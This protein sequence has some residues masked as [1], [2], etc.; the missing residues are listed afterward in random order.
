LDTLKPIV[1]LALLTRCL[2]AALCF[3]DE[4]SFM[5][6]KPASM[7]LANLLLVL[8]PATTSA[9]RLFRCVPYGERAPLGSPTITCDGRVPGATLELT[10]W[11]DNE[12]PDD[13]YADTSTECA[14]RLARL[15]REGGSQY[16]D[17]DDALVINN[18]FDT[19]GVLSAFAC[20]E[21]EAALRHAVLLADGAAAGDFGEWTSDAGVRLD[22]AI[23]AIGSAHEAEGDAAAYDAALEALP[24][25][26]TSLEEE[27][28]DDDDA[29]APWR[30]GWEAASAG[31][32][33]LTSGDASLSRAGA[34]A[35]L[36]EPGVGERA[37]R[38]PPA[39]LHRG[40]TQLLGASSGI[41]RVLRVTDGGAKGFSYEYEKPG[42]GWVK[43][44]VTREPVVAPDGGALAESLTALGGVGAWRKGGAGGLIALCASDGWVDAPPDAVCEAL[45]ACDEE[46]QEYVVRPGSCPA[47]C[48]AVESWVE[49]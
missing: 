34:I 46:A 17:H 42:H 14:L 12:T 8:A 2:G 49:S 18:H 27:E 40:L 19:D 21:P 10:H 43:R 48:G 33:A 5:I 22:A 28:A 11:T 30:D 47:Q 31:W 24:A 29:D 9:L 36:R 32:H 3:G 4:E 45:L 23:E 44:L 41:R 16:A 1:E 6:K 26:L 20:L 37:G 25:L 15:R 38:L 35:V 7:Q 13:L 39:S